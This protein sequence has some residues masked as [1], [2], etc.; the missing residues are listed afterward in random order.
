[1]RIIYGLPWG[2]PS[3]FVS[4]FYRSVLLWA[5]LDVVVCFGGEEAPF[6]MFFEV[7]EFA[8]VDLCTTGSIPFV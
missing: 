1:M 3:P 2:F 6:F 5:S 8:V 7:G 4:F